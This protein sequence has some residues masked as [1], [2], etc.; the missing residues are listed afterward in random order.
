MPAAQPDE[1]VT[2]FI[3]LVGRGIMQVTFAIDGPSKLWLRAM[4]PGKRVR[5]K[6]I[7][8]RETVEDLLELDPSV[9]RQMFQLLTGMSF[10]QFAEFEVKV[11]FFDLRGDEVLATYDPAADRATSAE[12]RSN[13]A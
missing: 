2:P 5:Y 13:A 10:E 3:I 6:A 11:E 8:L 4:R 1:E 7:V 9:Q 12:T